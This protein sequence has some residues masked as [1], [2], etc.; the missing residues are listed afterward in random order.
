[1]VLKMVIYRKLYCTDNGFDVTGNGT[2]PTTVLTLLATVLHR[3]RYRTGNRTGN[4][5]DSGSVVILVNLSVLK[6]IPESVRM[7]YLHQSKLCDN[8]AI[9]AI[10]LSKPRHQFLFSGSI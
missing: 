4:G 5:T 6:K 7:K 3:Q 2:A 9:V 1:M 8:R 10:L